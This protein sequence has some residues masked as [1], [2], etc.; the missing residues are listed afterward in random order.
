MSESECIKHKYKVIKGECYVRSNGSDSAEADADA[1][2]VQPYVA[3]KITS[4]SHAVAASL[5]IML[6]HMADMH[7][8]MFEVI[9]EKYNIP[10]D[11]IVEA[12]NS[13]P[14]V[15][16]MIVEPTLHSLNY[17]SQEDL[18]K[19]QSLFEETLT[20]S[21]EELTQ[22]MKTTT[23]DYTVEH[24]TETHPIVETIEPVEEPKPKTKRIIKIKKPAETKEEIADKV[25]EQAQVLVK[26]LP[27]SEPAPAPVITQAHV[28][29]PKKKR[30]ILKKKP[31]EPPQ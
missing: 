25:L 29:E 8:L 27:K 4:S 26:E 11:D 30:V 31:I 10:Y 1:D 2:Q 16:K 19:V 17:F 12:L 6:K 22:K 21:V 14:R 15:Q 23:I 20:N 24:K 3:Y 13:D 7:S 28:E 5:H 18:D 9:S